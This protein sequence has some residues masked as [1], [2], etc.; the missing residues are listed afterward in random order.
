LQSEGQI[1]TRRQTDRLLHTDLHRR[2]NSY[3]QTYR[4]RQAYMQRSRQTG[5]LTNRLAERQ[6]ELD[7]QTYSEGQLVINRHVDRQTLTETDRRYRKIYRKRQLQ[8]D[9][10]R[11]TINRD[12]QTYRETDLHRK[13]DK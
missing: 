10:Q 6:I 11:K 7:K 8:T 2:T 12:R 1:V 9:L 13:R 4:V 5:W 3:R